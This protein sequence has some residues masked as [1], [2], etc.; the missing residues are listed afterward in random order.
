MVIMIRLSQWITNLNDPISR[1]SRCS[2]T[3]IYHLNLVIS[4]GLFHTSVTLFTKFIFASS[5]FITYLILLALCTAVV[6]T[7]DVTVT[8]SWCNAFWLS[9][10]SYVLGLI[11]NELI[12]SIFPWVVKT[13]CW[14]V[15]T[16]LC[17]NF[18]INE[19]CET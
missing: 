6:L 19:H 10:A 8:Q 11:F 13:F 9:T 3:I 1:Y 4:L 15:L 5:T 18:I 14:H 17:E 7:R 2:L 16:L 12:K